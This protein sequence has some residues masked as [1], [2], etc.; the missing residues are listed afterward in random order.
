MDAIDELLTRG[1]EAIYPSYEALEKLLRSGKKLRLYQGFDPSMPSLHLGNFVGLMKLRQFQHQGHK[2]IFLVGD[3]TGMIGDPTDK[4][5]TRKKLTHE[6][7]LSNCRTWK[8][9]AS[10]I[11][12]FSGNNPVEIKYNNEW[13]GKLS[14][15][16]IIE[17]AA[18]FT[19][20][21]T[22]ERDMFQK[23]LEE[24][25]P[26][27]LHEFL[28]P[29]MQGYDSVAMD[30]D[31]EVGGTD[32]TFNML[33]GRHLMKAIKNK[34]KYVLSTKLLVDKE[35][36]KVGK[37]TGNALFLDSSPEQFFG[38]IMSFPDEV[39]KL[40]F[41]LLTQCPLDGLDQKIK[42]NPL[43]EKK[44]LAYEIV[45]ILWGEK[46]AQKAREYFENTFQK[47]SLPQDLPSVRLIG[48]RHLSLVRLLG[49][50]KLVNSNSEA[51]R[52]IGEK[53]VE[54]DGKSLTDPNL[55]IQV[56]EGM[57]IKVGKHRFIKIKTS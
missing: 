53:A 28:Y 17:L 36:N 46:S 41:E 24:K 47:K 5:A 56:K 45:N 7:V 30:V 51:K 33:A 18:N 32:Q 26:I 34:E 20:Q 35:G 52:L 1:V 22:L 37:T 29:L 12:N 2:V 23:R 44:R 14:F 38:G 57:V 40:S 10:S 8:T 49:E 15:T 43:Q 31:L 11:L 3:F 55:I 42:N 16:D 54:V 6:E 48:N 27:H 50:T 21:Q 13:L 25:K 4:L 9:Q 19:A 39:I